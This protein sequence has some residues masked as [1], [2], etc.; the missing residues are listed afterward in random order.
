MAFLVL[1]ANSVSGYTVKNSLRF[2][3]GSS[4][5]LSR[6]YGTPTNNLKYTKSFWIKRSGLTDIAKGFVWCNT[7]NSN[8]DYFYFDAAD[9]IL[10]GNGTTPETSAVF[11]DV[12][13]WY[14]CVMVFDSANATAANR[15]ILYINNV[16]QT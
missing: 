3:S 15:L 12:S 5:Y 11:R 13:A 16:Q 1:G 4:D 2:N 6:T 7:T 9:K 10:I 8:T 14:H